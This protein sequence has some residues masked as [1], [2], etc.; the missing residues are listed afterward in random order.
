MCVDD[1]DPGV[2][3]VGL[4]GP[5]TSGTSR[6]G[7]VGGGGVG[8]RFGERFRGE[9]WWAHGDSRGALH[10]VVAETQKLTVSLSHSVLL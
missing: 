1:E 2:F 8:G 3:I 5:W 7:C 4:A 9:G 10:C 6:G